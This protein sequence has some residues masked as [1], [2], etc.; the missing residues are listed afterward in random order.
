MTLPPKINFQILF[1]KCLPVRPV[2]HYCTQSHQSTPHNLPLFLV[3]AFV[4]LEFI[5]HNN[6]TYKINYLISQCYFKKSKLVEI[7]PWW[8]TPLFSS[9]LLPLALLRHK[10]LKRFWGQCQDAVTEH[11]TSRHRRSLDHWVYDSNNLLLNGN[12][13]WM[14]KAKTVKFFG[15]LKLL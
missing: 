10:Q 8:L 7:L 2:R 13:T 6:S 14:K 11:C 1:Q 15:N 3:A 9:N 12:R 5:L 4:R